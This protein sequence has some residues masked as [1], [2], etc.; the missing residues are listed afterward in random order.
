MSRQKIG[1]LFGSFNP[2]HTGHLILAEHMATRTDLDAV[3]LVVS[4]QSPFK[5]GEDLLPEADRYALVEAAIA[6]NDRLRVLDVEFGL[7]KPNFTIHTLDV[8]AKQYPSYE[9]VV[10]MG[11]DNLPGLPRWKDANRILTEYALY[12]YPRPGSPAPADVPTAVTIV[13]APLLDISATFIRASVRSGKSIRYLVPAAVE[14][15]IRNNRY[16]QQS[17]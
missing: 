12:V 14:E 8:L 15:I 5:V 2:I 7:P 1:L 4:P 6:G 17:Q 3:W 11:G 16:W 9:F 10:L 13:E